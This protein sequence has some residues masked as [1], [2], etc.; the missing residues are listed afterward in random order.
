LKKD[1]PE[2]TDLAE[3]VD[4]TEQADSVGE[5]VIA[6]KSIESCL[7]QRTFGSRRREV[8]SLLLVGFRNLEDNYQFVILD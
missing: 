8:Q 5:F 7:L 4:A 6:K 1:V 2:D 3:D